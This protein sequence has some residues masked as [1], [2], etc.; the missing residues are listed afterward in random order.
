MILRVLL[1]ICLLVAIILLVI[2]YSQT[3]KESFSDYMSCL[4]KG[5]TKMFCVKNKFSPDSC[6]CT[7]G[8]M[9]R[10]VPGF[11]GKCVCGSTSLFKPERQKITPPHP[12]NQT[13]SSITPNSFLSDYE[14]KR[15][16]FKDI[17]N[18]IPYSQFGNFSFF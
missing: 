16:I 15:Y 3:N 11:K 9:G 17:E 1:L 6:L 8:T 10:E 2:K 12:Q 5:F 18:I 13:P 4:K 14:Y 7:D